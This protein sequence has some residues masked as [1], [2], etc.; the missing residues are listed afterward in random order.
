[1]SEFYF[2]FWVSCP[3]WMSIIRWRS[4]KRNTCQFCNCPV[5]WVCYIGRR[6]H[7]LFGLQCYLHCKE[8][9]PLRNCGSWSCIIWH[10][11]DSRKSHRGLSEGVRSP[12][13]LR[14]FGS[15]SF[16]SIQWH[17]TIHI[18]IPVSLLRADV[19]SGFSWAQSIRSA[20]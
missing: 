19:L 12:A 8:S 13:T 15:G 2:K 18:N 9:H 11:H 3:S 17:C 6:I 14:I 16:V 10:F 1:M 20:L 4:T 5:I 7:S